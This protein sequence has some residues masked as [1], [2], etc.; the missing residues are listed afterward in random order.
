MSRETS[1][2]VELGAS[3]PAAGGANTCV[4]V[5]LFADGQQGAPAALDATLREL[6]ERVTS[7]GEFKGEEGTTLLIHA[8]AAD[9]RGARR[10]LLVGLGSRADFDAGVARRAAGAAVRVAK[11]ARTSTLH[12]VVPASSD[13]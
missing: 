3:L 8:P 4:A 6:C 2:S 12:F 10:V 1:L 9:G 7:E 11:S 5:G 13:A